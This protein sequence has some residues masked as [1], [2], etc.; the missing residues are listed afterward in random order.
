MSRGRPKKKPEIK[1]TETKKTTKEMVEE[2]EISVEERQ[3]PVESVVELF[4]TGITL[5]DLVNGGGLPWGK[6]IN[7][8][9]DKSS[10]KTI[11]SSEFIATA[12]KSINT[13]K[14]KKKVKW[15]YD[16]AEAGYSF[17]SQHLYGIDI[18]APDSDC[19]DT[20]EDF[21][22]RLERMIDE[23]KEDEYLIYVIDSFDSL[24]T[25]EELETYD[26]KM[27]AYEKNSK[28]KTGSY[29][30]SKSKNTSQFFRVIKRKLKNKN[31][32]LII[33]SQVRENIGVSFGAQYRRTGG[34]ALDFYAAQV[35]WLAEAQKHK[36][37]DRAYGITIK[38]KNTKNKIGKPF[39]EC[40][41]DIVFDY[42]VDNISSSIKFLYDL[43]TDGGKDIEGINKKALEWDG[44]DFKFRQLIR[45][46][47]QNNL[48]IELQNRV[49]E[50]WNTIEDKASVSK[51]RKKRF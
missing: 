22:L 43:K 2:I 32:L 23:V 14:S 17:N 37:M 30:T 27:K 35:I 6:M 13:K 49:I 36:K 40:Y 7:I 3:K 24:T 26:K 10:G 31:C 12:N 20:L 29:G 18:V 15:F 33:V 19:S 11:I 50:M 42:G 21:Q 16:D 8:I 44:K 9:G 48:E 39:R 34:K 25:D 47:E 4:S 41:I 45:H 5:W 51:G 1:N 38:A 28:D 46:I